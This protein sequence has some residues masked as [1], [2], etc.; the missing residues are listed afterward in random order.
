M[1]LYVSSSMLD[2]PT[3]HLEKGHSSPICSIHQ[4]RLQKAF[5]VKVRGTSQITNYQ[6]TM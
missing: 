3:K 5:L 2:K 6:Q 1:S 4:I